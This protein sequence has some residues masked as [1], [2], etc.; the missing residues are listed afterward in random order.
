M[1]IIIIQCT[2]N[3]RPMHVRDERI[4]LCMRMERAKEKD[5]REVLDIRNVVSNDITYEDHCLRQKKKK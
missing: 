3:S 2:S 5:F 1:A 4:F